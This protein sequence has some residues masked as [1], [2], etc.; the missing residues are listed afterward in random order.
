M[1][2]N[3]LSSHD[4]NSFYGEIFWNRAKTKNGVPFRVSSLFLRGKAPFRPTLLIDFDSDLGAARLMCPRFVKYK[5]ENKMF[6]LFFF[7]FYI[8]LLTAKRNEFKAMIG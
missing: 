6:V 3:V 4:G 5:K 1:A 2:R 8:S 7:I